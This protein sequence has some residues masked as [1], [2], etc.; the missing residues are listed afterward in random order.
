MKYGNITIGS[1]V[2][3]AGMP[4]ALGSRPGQQQAKESLG[5]KT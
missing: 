4:Q 2:E 1:S 3:V 5:L